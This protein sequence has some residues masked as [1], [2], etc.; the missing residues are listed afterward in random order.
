[1]LVLFLSRVSGNY[2]VEGC[3]YVSHWST[4]KV[5]ALKCTKGELVRVS[6]N[7]QNW[8]VFLTLMVSNSFCNT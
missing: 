7:S 6:R 5:V 8:F 4:H 1:M 2:S 3:S